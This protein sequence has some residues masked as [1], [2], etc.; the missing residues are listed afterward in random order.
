VSIVN[1]QIYSNTAPYGGGVY[2]DK[3]SVAIS[4]S[5]ISGNTAAKVRTRAQN[6]PSPR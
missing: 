1:S 6:F 3:G 4:S 2:V 5:T